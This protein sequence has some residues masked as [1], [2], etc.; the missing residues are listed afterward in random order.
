MEKSITYTKPMFIVASDG[1]IKTLKVKSTMP[2]KNAKALIK[3]YQRLFRKHA[4]QTEPE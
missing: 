1:E 3:F 2:L 4:K